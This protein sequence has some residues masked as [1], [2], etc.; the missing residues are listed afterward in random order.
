[1]KCCGIIIGV[2][3]VHPSILHVWMCIVHVADVSSVPKMRPGD[4]KGP[5]RSS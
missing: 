1:M 4:L 2:L 3:S 5:L